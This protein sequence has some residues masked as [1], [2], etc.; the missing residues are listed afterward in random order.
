MIT[1]IIASIII[2]FFTVAIAVLI[3]ALYRLKGFDLLRLFLQGKW[4][5]SLLTLAFVGSFLTGAV[6]LLKDRLW[7]APLLVYTICGW[8]IYLWVY[9]LKLLW[10]MYALLKWEK[11]T[12]LSQ[13]VGR[14]RFFDELINKTIAIS[15]TSTAVTDTADTEGHA[16]RDSEWEA[17]LHN[18]AFFQEVF[19]IAIRKKMRKKTIGLMVHTIINLIMLALLR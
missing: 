12:S 11:A 17:L 16:V 5:L 1:T 14:S 8:I 2:F 9:N 10:N 3:F 13:I 7:A 4:L 19:P 18:E 15:N 6:G